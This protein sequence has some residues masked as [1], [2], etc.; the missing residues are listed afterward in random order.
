[1]LIYVSKDFNCRLALLIINITQFYKQGCSGS[2]YVAGRK[3]ERH[4]AV[5]MHMGT[6]TYRET[7][8]SA[9]QSIGRH[10]RV[11]KNSRGL[12]NVIASQKGLK[13]RKTFVYRFTQKIAVAMTFNI[14]A[15]LAFSRALIVA[16][17]YRLWSLYFTQLQ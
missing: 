4:T 3:E 13:Y 1:M 7:F 15:K 14:N 6:R 12:Y 2:H 5:D 9:Q 11:Y 16:W 8:S 17:T 10:K